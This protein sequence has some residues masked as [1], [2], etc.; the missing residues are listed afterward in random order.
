VCF[1]DGSLAPVAPGAGK[2][3]EQRAL[4]L[5]AADGNVLLAHECRSASPTDVGARVGVV[6]L[7]DVRGLHAYYRDLTVRL[8]E[9]GWDAVAIDYFG[10]TAEGEDRGDAFPYMDHVMKTTPEGIALDVA[11]GVAHLRG[12]GVDHVYTLGFCFGGS[13]SWRQSADTPR[14]AGCIGFYGRSTAVLEVVDRMTAPLLM[15][16]AGADAHIPVSD[17]RLVVDA[18][19]VETE[20]VV[21]EGMPHSF[22]D[23]TAT[24]HA[25]ACTEAWVR[26]IDF[27]GRHSTST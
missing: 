7:P 11:A 22:F 20:L 15:L 18:A 27:V 21:F 25:D 14:L 12:L 5:T 24:E 19:P 9:V 4:T 10:R 16:V 13:Y 8:A 1:A 17:A 3:G 23:R 2:A 6:V 26:I